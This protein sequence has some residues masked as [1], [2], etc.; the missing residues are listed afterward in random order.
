MNS[1]IAYDKDEQGTYFIFTLALLNTKAQ[2]IEIPAKCWYLSVVR[3]QQCLHFASFL[4]SQ[5]C[6]SCSRHIPEWHI[7]QKDC[8]KQS[9]MVLE[10]LLL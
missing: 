7:C 3:V 8:P 4:S 6:T 2:C 9:N 10:S 1:M 5:M